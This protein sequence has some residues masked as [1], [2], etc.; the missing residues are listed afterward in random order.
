MY[1][2]KLPRKI[3]NVAGILRIGSRP[4][5]PGALAEVAAKLRVSTSQL[6]LARLLHR[7]PNIIAAD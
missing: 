2:Q 1:P 3:H 4:N 5:I 7:F 6:A